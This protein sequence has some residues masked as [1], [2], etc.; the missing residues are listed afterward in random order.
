MPASDLDLLLEAARGAGNVALGFSGRTAQR[1]DK[2]DGAGPVTEADIAVNNM[3]EDY[4]RK[5]RPDYGWLSEESD[6]SADRLDR[7][8][9]FIVDPIDGTR[10]FADGSDIWA[11]SI[12]IAQAGEITAAVVYL[13]A[14]QKTF[15]AAKGKGAFL[16]GIR[17]KVGGRRDLS[18]AEVLTTRP[19]LEASHWR[20]SAP[21]DIRRAHRPSLA[22]RMALVAQGKFDGMLTLRPAW[23]WDIAA[24]DLILREAGAEATDRRGNALIFN[25]PHPSQDGVI[26][27]GAAIHSQILERLRPI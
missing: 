26:A 17:I 8:H 27:A 18:G 3:L 25:N 1:W 12:A 6:D 9:V 10:S 21:P 14:R 19:N 22:Y 11:H 20:G 4:L 7:E 24:G 5:A 13:P 2:P 15:H 16:N 23:E